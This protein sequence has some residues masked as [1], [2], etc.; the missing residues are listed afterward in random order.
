MVKTAS[1]KPPQTLKLSFSLS[2]DGVFIVGGKGT[3]LIPVPWICFSLERLITYTKL[4]VLQGDPAVNQA[5]ARS[6]QGVFLTSATELTDVLLNAAELATQETD[7]RYSPLINKLTKGS[8]RRP[9]N[10]F[11]QQWESAVP[12]P[13][14]AKFRSTAD[15]ER[16]ANLIRTLGVTTKQLEINERLRRI[17][18]GKAETHF[19]RPLS[20]RVKFEHTAPERVNPGLSDSRNHVVVKDFREILHQL[21]DMALEKKDLPSTWYKL[22]NRQYTLKDVAAT[23]LK[24]RDALLLPHCLGFSMKMIF[25][26]T[27][28]LASITEIHKNGTLRVG[29]SEQTNFQ[30]YMDNFELSRDLL[31]QFEREFAE[32]FQPQTWAN[33]PL[34]SKKEKVGMFYHHFSLKSCDHPQPWT[35]S[36]FASYMSSE[37][38]KLWKSYFEKLPRFQNKQKLSDR[39]PRSVFQKAAAKKGNPNSHSTFHQKKFGGKGRQGQ[40]RKR[41]GNGGHGGKDNRGGRGK[42]GSRNRKER[43][44]GQ[45]AGTPATKGKS[46]KTKKVG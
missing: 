8:Q 41:K 40:K 21:S 9:P 17:K 16:D 43:G 45:G 3:N 23:G 1:Y 30:Q 24:E 13:E 33:L 20:Q 35:K 2:R 37:S 39:E 26:L 5:Q 38:A 25:N 11:S 46:K 27:H 34:A 18:T 36:T 10:I 6:L 15:L 14:K 29:K 28:L 42:R 19:F 44:R 7:P 4:A 22:I 31:S 32:F 12:A